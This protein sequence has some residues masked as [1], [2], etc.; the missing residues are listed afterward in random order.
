MRAAGVMGWPVAHSLSPAIHRFWLAA[1]GLDGDY[2]RFAVHPERLGAALGALGDLGL[3]GVNLTVP[4]KVPAL[5]HL[6]EVD[7]VARR[8]GAVNTVTM[9][10]DGRLCGTNTDVAG[11]LEPLA[12]RCF[13]H[14]VLLGAGGAAR[15]VVAA[16]P[17]L[18]TERLVIL[19]RSRTPAERLLAASGLQGEV[20]DLAAGAPA[21]DLLVN[22][23]SLGMAGQPPLELGWEAAGT[24]CDIVYQPLETALLAE[25]R[26]RG[27]EAIDGLHMLVGQA[28]GAFTLFF[29]ADPPRDMDG[30]LRA[31]LVAA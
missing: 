20:R 30:D 31:L 10:A 25:A 3:S 15:A 9:D 21:C 12:G 29:D 2:S 13:R 1:L 7:D 27:A 17:E 23:T 22:S 6:D 26:A 24:V 18:R 16:L 14:V 11:F 19:N 28:A 5:S 4:H 8:V